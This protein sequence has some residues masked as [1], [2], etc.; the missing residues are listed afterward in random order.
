MQLDQ[1]FE[2]RVVDGKLFAAPAVGILQ[3]Q[4]DIAAARAQLALVTKGIGIGETND[5]LLAALLRALQEIVDQLA[6]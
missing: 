6:R 1:R 2:Q 5:R 4:H 3:H